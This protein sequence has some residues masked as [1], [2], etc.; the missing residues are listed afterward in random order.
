MLC[1]QYKIGN[2]Y[3]HI[4]QNKN[5]KLGRLGKCVLTIN[6]KKSSYKNKNKSRLIPSAVF[7]AIIKKQVCSGKEFVENPCTGK[8]LI[9]L[10][11]LHI[12]YFTG[13][14]VE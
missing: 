6:I 3:F 12:L 7:L 9:Y 10:K 14:T 2:S 13:T 11:F 1:Q 5:K 8:I 4:A